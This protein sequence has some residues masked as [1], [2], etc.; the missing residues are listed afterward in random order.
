MT[1]N[2]VIALIL[3]R[4]TEFGT[5]P[6]TLRNKRLKIKPKLSATEM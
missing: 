3:S 6:G 4:F 1:F 5:F 2:G